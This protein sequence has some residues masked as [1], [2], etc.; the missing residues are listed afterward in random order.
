MKRQFRVIDINNIK[1]EDYS[2]FG[3][4]LMTLRLHDWKCS[5]I[6]DGRFNMTR[7]VEEDNFDSEADEL[8]E[9]GSVNTYKKIQ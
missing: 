9:D 7:L 2:S 3:L 8:F 4:A 1:P 5:S 6:I